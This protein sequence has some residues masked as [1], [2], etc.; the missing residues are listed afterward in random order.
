MIKQQTSSLSSSEIKKPYHPS[1]LI[2]TTI[3]MRTILDLI[4]STYTTIFASISI[5]TVLSNVYG[6][7]VT[8]IQQNDGSI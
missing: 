1:I 3:A 6:K 8:N 4:F 5:T 7:S 2:P